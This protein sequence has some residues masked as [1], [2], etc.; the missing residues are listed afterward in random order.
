MKQL[1]AGMN[2]LSITRQSQSPPLTDAIGSMV[3]HFNKKTNRFLNF[4]TYKKI[5]KK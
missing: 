2:L 5:K 4:L 1:S 3:S